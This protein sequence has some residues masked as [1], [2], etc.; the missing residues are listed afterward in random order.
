VDSYSSLAL[1]WLASHPNPSMVTTDPQRW[2]EQISTAMTRR[3]R[4]LVDQLAPT[5]PGERYPAR[6]ARLN[7]AQ[8]AA[9][10]LAVDELL[11][12]YDPS[13]DHPEGW[14]PLLPDLT[15]LL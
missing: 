12:S 9:T 15:D 2:A 10:E 14:T 8:L 7:T 11:P 4:E 1:D 5:I 6:R 13:P 3:I